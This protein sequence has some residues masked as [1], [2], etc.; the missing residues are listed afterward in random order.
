MLKYLPILFFWLFFS[1]TV[2]AQKQPDIISADSTDIKYWLASYKNILKKKPMLFLS[3]DSSNAIKP[4]GLEPSRES[5]VK[6]LNV[7][8]R[9]QWSLGIDAG[10][11]LF[12][13]GIVNFDAL[14]G[15]EL[16][17]EDFKYTRTLPTLGFS[18]GLN[19]QYYF[20]AKD[21]NEN[22][23]VETDNFDQTVRK[24]YKAPNYF[25]ILGGLQY[26][27]DY[28]NFAQVN[29]LVLS[30]YTYLVRTELQKI[31]IP[32]IGRYYLNLNAKPKSVN[33]IGNIN[34]NHPSVSKNALFFGLGFQVGYIFSADRF[35]RYTNDDNEA[36]LLSLITDAI[37]WTGNEDAR[38]PYPQTIMGKR[39]FVNWQF[40]A[41]AELGYRLRI[42]SKTTMPQYLNIGLSY[43]FPF[44]S[45]YYNRQSS[46]TESINNSE[47]FTVGYRDVTGIQRI[48]AVQLS[49]GF[50]I[51]NHK[52][53]DRYNSP[54]I[55]SFFQPKKHKK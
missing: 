45:Y 35:Y 10:V 53:I 50:E 30:S 31:A 20:F 33:S 19:F 12:L 52:I 54:K 48:G 14:T 24:F 28:Y 38:F 15:A 25:S 44:I 42:N 29:Y 3:L 37:N 5:F 16:P 41:I 43:K 4:T 26:Q 49:L 32:L 39:G 36:V 11:P 6:L 23:F 2:F 27:I 22:P 7:K 1:E 17:F 46:D 34:I 8:S 18:T 47:I 51:Q 13:K 55:N 21:K 9:P 40:D